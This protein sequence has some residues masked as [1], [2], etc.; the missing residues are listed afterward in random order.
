MPKSSSMPPGLWL[1]DMTMPP[2]HPRERMAADAAGVDM[3]APLPTTTRATPLAAAT[4]RMICAA[5]R[6]KKR[7]SPPSTSVAP[8]SSSPSAVKRHCTQL[9]R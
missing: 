3:T 2:R 5:S 1:A 6:L 9:A 8:A 4:L 7:P